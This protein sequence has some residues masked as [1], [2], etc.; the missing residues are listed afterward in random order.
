MS[1]PVGAVMLRLVLSAVILAAMW[2]PALRLL[3][4]AN[5]RDLILF[6]IALA[7]MNTSFYAALDRIPL[8]IAVTLEFV[9]PLGVAIA[10]SR[11]RARPRLGGARRSRDRAPVPRDRRRP[12]P[13]RRRPGGARGRLLGR[14]HLPRPRG[15]AP[16][17]RA[18]RASRWRWSS[19][20]LI[21]LPF[22]DRRGRVRPPRPGGPRAWSRGRGPELG[23]PLLARARGAAPPADGRLRGPDEPRAGVAATI[24]FL[25]LGQDLGLNE[26]A[27]IACVV[28]ASA[29]ALRGAR[30]APSSHSGAAAHS[31]ASRAREPS[32]RDPRLP[33]DRRR[34]RPRRLRRRRPL[35]L[36]SAP[37]TDGDALCRATPRPAPRPPRAA[38]SRT[39]TSNSAARI[40]TRTSPP[41]T[42]RRTRRPAATTTRTRLQAG[43]YYEDPPRLGE[44][45]HL[46]EHGAVIGWTNDL[47]KADLKA[48]E[49][50][51]NSDLPGRLLPARRGRE[52]GPRRP[53]RAQRLGRAADVRQGRHVGDP[54]VRRG[55]VRLAEDRRGR[56]RLSGRRAD[57]AQL[58]SLIEGASTAAR[59]GFASLRLIARA[60][61]DRQPRVPRVGRLDPRALAEREL[62]A[63]RVANQALVQAAFAEA[64]GGSRHRTSMPGATKS[65]FTLYSRCGCGPCGDCSAFC[66]RIAAR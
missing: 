36:D 51:F 58:L 1:D 14:L 43:T 15:S 9:G 13:A 54:A 31:L 25:A 53:L 20:A 44:A 37:T 42:T 55:V 10:G 7:G 24:G 48:I 32:R 50:E 18:A 11:E 62:R 34:L 17:S 23:D 65:Y 2:R 40:W 60:R 57:A 26:A 35:D 22:G 66:G 61:D 49:D 6:G 45:V 12:R 27:A 30:R 56:A 3:R 28:A 39:S 46:L 52:P 38:R 63:A 16:R 5:R 8:G 64:G 19:R 41:P 21:L 47:S 4:G 33:A 29:G 59:L